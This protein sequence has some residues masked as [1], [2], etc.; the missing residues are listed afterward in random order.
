VL[1]QA[2]VPE[3][4]HRKITRRDGYI[5]IAMRF[6][7]RGLRKALRNE[8]ISD[9]APSRSLFNKWRKLRERYSHSEAIKEAE[10]EKKFSL[11][12]NGLTQLK[13]LSE[14]SKKR[15]VF[16]VCQ[17]PLGER[18]HREL[19]LIAAHELFGAKVGRVYNKYSKYVRRLR[20]QL[21]HSS[22]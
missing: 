1:K 21:N 20:A 10:Y 19:L 15:D 14:L 22:G 11:T 18:C 3:I 7:P 5:V 9:L 2:S 8:Y 4:F 13:R 16:L 12:P 17:C 6:Y